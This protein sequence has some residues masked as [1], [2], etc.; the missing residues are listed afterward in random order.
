P[1]T[2]HH[3]RKETIRSTLPAWRKTTSQ[4][5]QPSRPPP[6]NA[7]RAVGRRQSVF[8]FRSQSANRQSHPLPRP[9]TKRIA[10]TKF[11]NEKESLVCR[12]SNLEI[13]AAKQKPKKRS[14]KRCPKSRYR[15]DAAY[16][17]HVHYAT[18][19]K[20]ACRLHRSHC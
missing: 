15:R 16:W 3:S 9:L 10:A 2:E 1:P 6:P 8:L 4:R 17:C 5:E 11:E 19:R 14:R 18:D 13:T 7:V 12:R 20:A